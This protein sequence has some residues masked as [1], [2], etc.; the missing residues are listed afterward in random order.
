M[1]LGSLRYLG[2]GW[3]FDDVEENTGVSAETH[4]QFF[5]E[6]IKIGSTFLY[7]QYEVP[8]ST[9]EEAKDHMFEME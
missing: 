6:F 7:D 1:I 2:R 3:T 9:V 8:P 5:H 4:Q